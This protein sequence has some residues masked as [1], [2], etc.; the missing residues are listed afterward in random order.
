MN[1][2]EFDAPYQPLAEINIIPFVDVMLVLLIIFMITAPLLTPRLLPVNLPHVTTETATSPH[3]P[4][5]LTVDAQN[6]LFL[7][8]K[9]VSEIQL[10]MQLHQLAQQPS[11]QMLQL[12]IDKQ[13]TYQR[14]A[15][16]L[17]LVQHAGI[18]QVG[19]TVIAGNRAGGEK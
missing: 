7:N 9:P 17:S 3:T 5:N 11:P 4:L 16:V 14:I 15:E 13:V 2:D 12:Q 18:A 10:N 8:D 6:H 19:L 1:D